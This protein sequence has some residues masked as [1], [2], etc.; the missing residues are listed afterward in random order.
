[1]PL[2][3]ETEKSVAE[4]VAK[5]I[6]DALKPITTANAAELAKRDAE[7][8]VLKMTDAQKAFMAGCSEDQK[9]AFTEMDAEKR[10]AFMADNPHV[11]K[12]EPA[13]KRDVVAVSDEIAKRDTQ[14]ADLKKRL[15]AADLKEAQTSF[16]KRAA[17]AGLTA[18]GDG[19]IMRKAY[20]GDAASQLQLEA[21]FASIKKAA[22][23]ALETAGV[24]KEFG[25]SQGNDGQSGTAYAALTAKAEEL[26]K[27]ESG[28]GLTQAQ[29]FAKV[30]QDPANR[31]LADREKVESRK[32]LSIVA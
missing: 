9:K 27:T 4:I 23:A 15:D 22:D 2:T 25:T 10:D 18:A 8:A 19:E 31:E 17:D 29:A 1:M 12:G 16:V 7:I 13:T 20:S 21:R 14:I 24:F 5:A 30:Y 32:R 28:K 3:A 26:R 6:A 11:K